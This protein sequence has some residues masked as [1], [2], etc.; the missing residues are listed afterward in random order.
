MY[1]IHNIYIYATVRFITI[2]VVLRES[3]A[4]KTFTYQ[5]TYTVPGKQ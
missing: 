3:T 4:L 1:N 5:L 2:H